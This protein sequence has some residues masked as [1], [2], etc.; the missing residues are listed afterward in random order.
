MRNLDLEFDKYLDKIQFVLVHKYRLTKG[1]AFNKMSEY[2]FL[3][4][5]YKSNKEHFF[6]HSPE[7]WANFIM[8]DL[9]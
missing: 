9:T 7:Y 6:Y 2:E 5:I 8:E 1:G 3:S 4:D